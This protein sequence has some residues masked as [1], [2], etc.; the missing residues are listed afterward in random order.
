[1]R[2][3]SAQPSTSASKVYTEDPKIPERA[4]PAP[5]SR[6]STLKPFYPSKVP[7][8][9]DSGAF[10]KARAMHTPATRA[11]RDNR[12]LACCAQYKDIGYAS[13]PEELKLQKTREAVNA[14]KISG[15][16]FRPTSRPKT[17]RTQSIM[18]HEP[19]V[20]PA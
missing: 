19:G 17:M 14:A 6:S 10:T 18:F 4:E 3:C 20:S 7:V 11:P 15:P 5:A 12:D 2:A 16:P 1:M 8:S 13:D 9:G